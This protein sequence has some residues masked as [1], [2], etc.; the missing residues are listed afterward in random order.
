MILIDIVKKFLDGECDI[1]EWFNLVE[2]GV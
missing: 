1:W 2:V